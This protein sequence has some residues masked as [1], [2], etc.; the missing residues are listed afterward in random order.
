MPF[1]SLGV[2]TPAAGATTA[3]PGDI[4]RS[5]IWNAIFE[6]IS[7]ALTELGQQ[8][9]GF[10]SVTAATYA[11]VAADSFLLVNRAGVVTI[12]LPTGASR[13]GYPLTIKDTSGA[14][15]TNNITIDGN[16]AEN[17][18]GLAT[19]T[20][21]VAYGGYTLYPVTGGWVIKP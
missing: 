10:T 20:I 13:N 17:I 14:A 12:N 15:Q 1:N 16:G 9:Y 19:I 11:P 8:V 5:A 7:D 21:D 6:D 2:Y 18:D 4:I 3:A